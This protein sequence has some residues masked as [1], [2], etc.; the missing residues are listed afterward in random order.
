MRLYLVVC[1]C[2]TLLVTS[3]LIS[4]DALTAPY[5][6]PLQ[7]KLNDSTLNTVLGH[8]CYPTTASFDGVNDVGCTRQVIDNVFHKEEITALHDIARK[9]MDTRPKANGPTI[10]DINTGFIRDSNGMDNLFSS[11]RT[12]KL[13]SA[14]EFKTYSDIITKLKTLVMKRFNID[15]GN[16]Y[17]T[18]PTFITRLVGSH[19]WQPQGIHDEYWHVH[20]D[21][22]NTPHYH[23]SGLLY[24]SDYEK[25]F[26]GGRLLFYDADAKISVDPQTYISSYEEDAIQEIVE[27]RMGRVVT[28]SSGPENPHKVEKVLSGERAVL[29]FWFTCSQDREFEIY[30][31]GSSHDTFKRRKQK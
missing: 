3:I 9:G 17:F 7:C 11:A 27:P 15:E 1:L 5:H 18:A 29:A 25:D 20:V 12:E 19:E 16:L 26:T 14:D 28:F 2:T 6:Q 30:L 23:Y 22:N 24:L 4:K 10:L 8:R 13:Y 21:R 31:D